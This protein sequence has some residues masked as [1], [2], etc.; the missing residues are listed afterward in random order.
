MIRLPLFAATLIAGCSASD[1]LSQNVPTNAVTESQL[2]EK[3]DF[4][5]AIPINPTSW[6]K[7]FGGPEIQYL[8][9][10]VDVEFVITAAGRVERCVVEKAEYASIGD[11][12]CAALVKG[13]RFKPATG[14]THRMA[15]ATHGRMR[16]RIE[17]PTE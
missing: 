16:L 2:G 7:D 10:V 4:G 1:A 12:V 13:A 17:R 5:G 11:E 9:A 14:G 3:G 6:L 15:K 8:P